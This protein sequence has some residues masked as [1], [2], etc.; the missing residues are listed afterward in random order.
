M[1]EES[2]GSYVLVEKEDVIDAIATFVAAYLATVPRCAELLQHI[3]S[4]H[5]CVATVWLQHASVLLVKTISP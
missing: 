5:S 4:K 3:L 1:E 2:F